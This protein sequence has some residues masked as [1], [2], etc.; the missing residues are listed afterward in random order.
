MAVRHIEIAPWGK[1]LV[2]IASLYYHNT[3]WAAEKEE[4]EIKDQGER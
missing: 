2:E 3:S 4:Y 1:L